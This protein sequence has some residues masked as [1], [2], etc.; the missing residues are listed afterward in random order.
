MKKEEKYRVR[1]HMF[2]GSEVYAEN[3]EGYIYE[4]TF[5]KSIGHTGRFKGIE[6]GLNEYCR[7]ERKRNIKNNFKNLYYS[8]IYWLK[9]L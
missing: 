5:N 4:I 2:K 8:I 7:K 3:N 9:N 6:D 1:S